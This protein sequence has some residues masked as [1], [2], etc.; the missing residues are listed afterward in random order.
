MKSEKRIKVIGIIFT[1]VFAFVVLRL[2]QIMILQYDMYTVAAHRQHYSERVLTAKRGEIYYADNY[3]LVINASNYLLFAVP[4]EMEDKRETIKLLRDVLVTFIKESEVHILKEIDLTGDES[5]QNVTTEDDDDIKY[6]I[7]YPSTIHSIKKYLIENGGIWEREI[8]SIIEDDLTRLF[9]DDA[10]Q[11]VQIVHSLNREQKN[12]IEELGLKG[13]HFESRESRLYP[14]GDIAS[15]ILGIVGKD[16]GGQEQG[17]FGLEGYYNGYLSGRNG[18]ELSERDIEGKPIPHGNNTVSEPTHGRDLILTVQREVQYLVENK[19]R[20][21]IDRYG[22][23]SGA[24]IVLDPYT[25]AVIALASYPSY[26][27]AFWTDELNGTSDVSKVDVFRNT[28]ISSNYEPGSVMKPITMAMAL[29]EGLVRPDSIFSDNGPVEYSGYYVRTWNNRYAGDITMSQVLQM[30][31]NTGAAWVG[32]QVGFEKFSDYLAKFQFGTL[33]GI[34]LEGEERGIVRSAEIWRDIDLA[35]MSFG[36]G[37]SATPLQIAVAFCALVNGGDIVKP[38][39]VDKM[40]RDV[41]LT[42]SGEYQDAIQTQSEIKQEA[43]SALTSD[44]L[45]YMLETVV[46]DGEFKWFVKHAGMDVYR[47]GGKTGTAQ[48]PIGGEYDPNNTNVTFVG[49]A[50]VE[51]P[52][53]VMLMKLSEPSASTYSADTVVPIWMETAKGLMNHFGISPR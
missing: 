2:F 48:I 15:H 21:G 23:E 51:E 19:L 18:Y 37:I 45:R 27:P 32:H 14:D 9:E 53:F 6:S 46:T 4:M 36:Q 24:A 12:K 43:L 44:Q 40:V 49:F 5:E 16:S 29:N 20:E 8:E 28:V 30:S 39:I 13:L 22:A 25:G 38:Y 11:Y 26:Y 35:N 3:P 34:D 10:N 31:N 7:Y 1:V 33:T 42:Y 50:P 47:M 52:K 17:Y 41:L